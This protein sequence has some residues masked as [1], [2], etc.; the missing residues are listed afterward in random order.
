VFAVLCLTMM[1]GGALNSFITRLS[2]FRPAQIARK[3]GAAKGRRLMQKQK[4]AHL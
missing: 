1:R 3:I 2:L 4:Y